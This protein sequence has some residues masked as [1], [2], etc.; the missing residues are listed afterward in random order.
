ML[1]RDSVL[2]GVAI[3]ILIELQ[4]SPQILTVACATVAAP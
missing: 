4:F 1:V 3:K 2:S